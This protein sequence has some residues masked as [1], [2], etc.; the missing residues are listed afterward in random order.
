MARRYRSGYKPRDVDEH[1]SETLLEFR[2]RLAGM[3]LPF[4]ASM[5]HLLERVE[6]LSDGEVRRLCE[7]RLS[8][9]EAAMGEVGS[10]LA[11]S[12]PRAAPKAGGV[13]AIDA[14]REY[15]ERRESPPTVTPGAIPGAR[16]LSTGVAGVTV[17]TGTPPMPAGRG[18]GARIEGLIAALP[19]PADG[20]PP[21]RFVRVRP[22]DVG[23]ATVSAV[24]NKLRRERGLNVRSYRDGGGDV[25][26]VREHGPAVIKSRKQRKRGA[27][28]G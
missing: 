10:G 11:R 22:D 3:G 1:Y 27:S 4:A 14:T 21:T 18:K 12:M 26:V 8:E 19:E 17:E 2:E 9:G 6:L 23:P 16:M 28:N 5:M 24:V 13:G 7:E 15:P 20:E 25:I